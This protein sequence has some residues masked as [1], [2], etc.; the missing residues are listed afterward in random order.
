M[1]GDPA[2]ILDFLNLAKSVN[3]KVRQNLGWSLVYNAI[4]IPV[5]M[6]GLLNPLIAVSAMLMSS[7]S[8]IGNTLLLTKK[9]PRHP[10]TGA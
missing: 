5:A 4:S 2:Q 10:A 6:S 1:R 9:A 7:L 8:V 3:A